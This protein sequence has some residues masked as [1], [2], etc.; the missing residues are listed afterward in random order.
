MPSTIAAE[1][2][3]LAVEVRRG[4]EHQEERR[5]GR[6][7]VVGAGHGDDAARVLNVVAE[8]ALERLDPAVG[9]VSGAVRAGL[10]HAALHHEILDHAME[11]RAVVPAGGGEL[12]E[13]AHVIGRPVRLHLDLD[14]AERGL[15]G[16]GLA[17]LVERG[18]DERL[19][20]LLLDG[21][22]DECGP[23]SRRSRS[24]PAGRLRDLLHHVHAFGDAAEGGDTC[25]RAAAAA[26]RRRRTARRR[27]RAC[28]GCGRW[29]RRRARA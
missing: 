4:A 26:R 18:V 8:L 15:E 29:R 10:P 1:G 17:H 23:A 16:D 27:Y 13:I 5:G 14:G 20:L 6:I 19:H 7:R 24:A 2:G 28:P 25:R 21:H 11:D 3:V 9:R 22:L 12:E